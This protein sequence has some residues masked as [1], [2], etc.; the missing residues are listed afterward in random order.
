[1]RGVPQT[2][3]TPTTLPEQE[4]KKL[5]QIGVIIFVVTAVGSD[6]LVDLSKLAI[7][8]RPN[9]VGAFR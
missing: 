6:Y 4:E 3:I 5:A 7:S 1:M 9:K 8:E 2:K